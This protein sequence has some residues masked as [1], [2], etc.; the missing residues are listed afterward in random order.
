MKRGEDVP[1]APIAWEG[2]V[3]IGNAGGDFKGAKGHMYALDAETGK[4]VWQFFLVPKTEGDM[5]RGPEG[6]SPLDTSTWK[7]MPGA[8]IGGG[9]NWTST[10][11]DP[12]TG[13][14]YVPVGNPAPDYDNTS[15]RETISSPARSLSST[16]RPALTRSIFSL[17]PGIGTIGTSPTRPLFFRRRAARN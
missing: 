15:V 11:L 16:P 1:A 6:A 4:I 14:L 13:L 5:V 10:T 7:N 12:A 8:P 17:C 2:L 9:G 3:F